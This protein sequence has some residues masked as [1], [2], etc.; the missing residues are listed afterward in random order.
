MTKMEK[1][2]FGKNGYKVKTET[3]KP[4]SRSKKKVNL[5]NKITAAEFNQHLYESMPEEEHQKEL[6]KWLEKS[7]LYYEIG[8]EVY[9]DITNTFFHS[10]SSHFR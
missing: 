10:C 7:Q 5:P 8:L 4:I 1:A 3:K 6:I 2:I 9:F